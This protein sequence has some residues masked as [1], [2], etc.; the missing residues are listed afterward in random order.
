MN[1][2]GD[3]SALPRPQITTK[4]HPT[5]GD[6]PRPPT[7]HSPAPAGSQ[8]LSHMRPAAPSARA[9]LLLTALPRGVPGELAAAWRP[10]CAALQ[11]LRPSSR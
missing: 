3:S 1:V 9:S 6:G 4:P 11:W 10:G 7:A 5:P 8:Y 2:G